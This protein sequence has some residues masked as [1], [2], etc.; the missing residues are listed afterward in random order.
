MSNDPRL[1]LGDALQLLDAIVG[2]AQDAIV[3]ADAEGC[4][5]SLSAAGAL[6]LGLARSAAAGK[7][8]ADVAPGVLD[9]LQGT[10]ALVRLDGMT[11]RA[12]VEWPDGNTFQATIVPAPGP[13]PLMVFHDASELKPRDWTDLV[14]VVSHDLKAPLSVLYGYAHMLNDAPEL[15]PRSH[16]LV[17]AIIENV[18]R[19]HDLIQSLL[20]LAQIEAGMGGEAEPCDL[21]KLVN[22]AREMLERQAQDKRQ[23]LT[24][25]LA[26]VSPV[27]ANPVRLTQVIY[28]LVGNAIK[29]T[30]SGGCI[31]VTTEQPADQVRLVVKDNGPGIPLSVQPRL[32]ERFYRGEGGNG[33]T[34]GTGLGLAIVKS[35]VESYGGSVWV[36]SQPGQGSTFGCA[37]P[38][39][40][41]DAVR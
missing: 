14:T 15:S 20:D 21:V 19:M 11:R 33:N 26:P 30:P 22:N 6:S 39:P 7:N 38:V 28:N 40:P 37:L 34:D 1:T 13:G 3:I 24:F 8:L 2:D 27:V 9:G 4:V 17:H 10:M 5:H 32:F 23:T 41:G 31:K 12:E 25:E 36:A 35:I 29:Y 16:A 18:N